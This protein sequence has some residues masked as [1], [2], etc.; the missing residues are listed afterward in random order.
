MGI[1]QLLTKACA[2]AQF[3]V[4]LLVAFALILRA[5]HSSDPD[6]RSSMKAQ[7]FASAGTPHVFVI[8]END[9]W[10]EPLRRELAILE[11][12]FR[13]WFLDEGMLDLTM[14]PPEGV[15]YN[16]MS[17]SS[18]T[19]G[20]RYAPELTACT[21]AWLEMHGRR[22]INDSRALRLEI[23]KVAQYATLAAYGIRTPHTVAAVGRQA[24]VAAAEEVTVPFIT[25][26]NRA[27]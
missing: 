2:G 1:T 23:S 16:R 11:V 25:K 26:H 6:P 21:L 17:A 7:R 24:I 5:V 3:Q 12:P 19:R 13:E 8:H 27:G 9:T 10:V 18:H 20:H 14:A 22:V 4:F 15:F